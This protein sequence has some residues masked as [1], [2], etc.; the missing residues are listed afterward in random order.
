ML[1]YTLPFHNPV[2]TSW[3]GGIDPACF[4]SAATAA[5]AAVDR[6]APDP[7]AA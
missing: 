6:C 5:G 1:K 2:Q 3:A 4:F 7:V